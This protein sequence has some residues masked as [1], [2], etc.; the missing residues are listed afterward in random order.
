MTTTERVAVTI[1]VPTYRRPADLQG[2]IP[3]LLE[4]ARAL[5]LEDPERYQANVLIVDNDPSASARAV[6]EQFGTNALRYVHEPHAGIAAVRNRAIEDSAEV[7]LLAMIDDDERPQDRWLSSLV[8]TWEAERAALV[9]GR[10][11]AAYAGPLDPWIAAGEFFVRR[12]MPTGS[13]ITVAAAGN[14]LLD[15]RQIRALGVR[16]DTTLGL[17]GGEDTVFSRRLHRLGGRMVWCAESVIVDQVPANRMTRRWVLTRAWSHGNAATFTDLALAAGPSARAVVR[18]RRTVG[19]AARVLIGGG[20]FL[21]GLV[22]ASPRHQARGLRTTL[23]GVG[24]IGGALG[25]TYHEYARTG[26]AEPGGSRVAS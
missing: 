22:L 7:D 23:R 4:Q 10:V 15:L 12:N 24:M 6:C 25:H 18:L 17:G 11:I 5:E 13:E 16:F 26:A 8:S 1:A 20:R 21:G 14:L 9:S 3:M 19:G 2:L